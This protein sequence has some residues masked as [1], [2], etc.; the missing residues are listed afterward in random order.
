MIAQEK[1]YYQKEA[2]IIQQKQELERQFRHDLN[3]RLQILNDIAERGNI[4]ELKK[5]TRADGNMY[6]FASRQ[7]LRYDVVRLG[8]EFFPLL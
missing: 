2:E 8:N 7:A 1:E 5:L 4:S 3:N 6:T